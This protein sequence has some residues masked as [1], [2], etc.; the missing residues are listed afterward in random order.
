MDT[1]NTPDASTG[2]DARHSP[3]HRSDNALMYSGVPVMRKEH[4]EAVQE[5]RRDL[6]WTIV[7]RTSEDDLLLDVERFLVAYLLQGPVNVG[8]S[9]SYQ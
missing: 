6:P 7:G 3:G 8:D 4:V 1:P 5:A 2:S 9:G